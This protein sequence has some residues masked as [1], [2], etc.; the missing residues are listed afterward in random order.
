MARQKMKCGHGS[1]HGYPQLKAA[2]ERIAGQYSRMTPDALVLEPVGRAAIDSPDGK[3][4]V[5]RFIFSALFVFWYSIRLIF[6]A[7]ELPKS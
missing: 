4:K 2:C 3:I 5:T 6:L 1:H 7:P